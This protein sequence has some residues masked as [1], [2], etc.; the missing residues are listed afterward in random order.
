MKMKSLTL[1]IALTFSVMFS[2][3]SYAGWTEVGKIVSGDTFYVD[4]ERIRKVDG[5]VYY[6]VLN[7]YL[8]PNKFGTLSSKVY[9]Q[10]D[11]KLF[12]HKGLSYSYHKEPMGGGTGDTS[13]DPD[14]EWTYPSPNSSGESI[15]EQVCNR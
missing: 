9:Y 14:T 3:S 4:F 1:F 10:G 2:S 13:N 8:K 15:L 5:Y 11:C 12:R 6:W 7:D